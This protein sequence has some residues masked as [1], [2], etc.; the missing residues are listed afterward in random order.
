MVQ[1]QQG[2]LLSE[3]FGEI[4]LSVLSP[5]GL[6][7]IFYAMATDTLSLPFVQQA[8]S[9]Q[10]IHDTFRYLRTK[11]S[12]ITLE[13]M[14]SATATYIKKLAEDKAERDELLA[15]LPGGETIVG[16]YPQA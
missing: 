15:N 6:R 9:N 7:L 13:Q 11:S 4:S 3:Q 16:V 12:V 14:I 5:Q 2:K 1:W 8:I 10:I